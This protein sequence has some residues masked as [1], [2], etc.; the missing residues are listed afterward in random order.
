MDDEDV[1]IVDPKSWICPLNEWIPQSTDK[2]LLRGKPD[3]IVP[4]IAVTKP[5]QSV[6]YKTEDVILV[7]IIHAIHNLFNILQTIHIDTYFL[8]ANNL[9]SEFISRGTDYT[10]SHS[11]LIQYKTYLTKCSAWT[12]SPLNT[13]YCPRDGSSEN[14]LLLP[15]SLARQHVDSVQYLR[16]VASRSPGLW[17]DTT[18]PESVTLTSAHLV[19]T[20]I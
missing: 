16:N 12:W 13:P 3:G 18:S 1:P 10:R 7:K 6:I 20:L 11:D 14:I 4:Y 5:A 8:N 17:N 15:A 2:R 19:L 9:A